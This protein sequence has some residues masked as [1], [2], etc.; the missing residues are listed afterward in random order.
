[1]P[2]SSNPSQMIDNIPKTPTQTPMPVPQKAPAAMKKPAPSYRK[3]LTKKEKVTQYL[4]KIEQDSAELVLQDLL[5]EMEKSQKECSLLRTMNL[6]LKKEMDE[7]K[8]QLIRDRLFNF[9]LTMEMENGADD[10]FN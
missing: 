6:G 3:K 2:P 9:G 5:E 8:S 1:M 10:V 7:F 4:K